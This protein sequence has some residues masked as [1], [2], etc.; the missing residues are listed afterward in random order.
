MFGISKTIL[1]AGTKK[2]IIGNALVIWMILSAE[3][4]K[5]KRCFVDNYSSI[6]QR[7]CTFSLFTFFH[8]LRFFRKSGIW[9]SFFVTL[10][11][12]TEASGRVIFGICIVGAWGAVYLGVL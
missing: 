4:R 6:L 5:K 8:Y 9:I 11:V 12:G 2:C 1:H 7:S 3:K 10:L